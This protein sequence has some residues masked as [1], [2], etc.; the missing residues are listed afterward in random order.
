MKPFAFILATL[1]AILAYHI[2][3]LNHS[4]CPLIWSF[5]DFF[6]WPFVWLKWLVCHDVNLTII[7]EA[8][9]WFLK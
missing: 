2:N 6:L 3:V 9:A 8:F 7:K 1:T 5:I 4:V